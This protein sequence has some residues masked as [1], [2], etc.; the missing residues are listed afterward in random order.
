MAQIYEA[1]SPTR[2]RVDVVINSRKHGTSFIIRAGK[3]AIDFFF[4][5]KRVT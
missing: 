4:S 2:G 1:H 3:T 5:G